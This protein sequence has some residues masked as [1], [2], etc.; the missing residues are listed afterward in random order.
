MF[1]QHIYYTLFFLIIF[2]IINIIIVTQMFVY[3]F[4]T[5]K[6]TTFQVTINSANCKAKIF[7]IF[8][9]EKLCLWVNYNFFLNIEKKPN[10]LEPS[11]L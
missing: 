5:K 10:G 4:E 1:Q 11:A 2:F 9:F 8:F 3:K 6:L 7:K